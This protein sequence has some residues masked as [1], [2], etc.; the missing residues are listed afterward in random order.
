MNRKVLFAGG[1]GNQMFQYAFMLGLRNAGIDVKAD[2]SIYN[3]GQMHNG[4]ELDKVFGIKEETIS[5]IGLSLTMLKILRTY[6]KGYFVT[7][8]ECEAKFPLIF[9]GYWQN[10][11]FFSDCKDEIKKAF[12]F[13]N[14]DDKNMELAKEMMSHN[15]VSVHIRRGDYIGLKR[16]DGICTDVY[17]NKAI[18]IIQSKT[19]SPKF[20]FF[21][22]EPEWVNNRFKDS[23]LDYQVVNWNQGM[24]SYKDLFLITQCRHHII[25]NSS[26]SWWGAW[27]GG[28]QNSI[29]I[30]PHRWANGAES[31]HPQLE[32]WIKI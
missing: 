14:I 7:T 6:G 5:R 1:L 21:S 27:L 17:Y 22:N 10:E 16:F 19:V 12:T 31:V 25:A 24:D 26:F 13:Q 28:W 15:S 3:C 9:D 20:Y 30:S 18:S 2:I 29:V 32:S 11:A 23:G 4:Y 8:E